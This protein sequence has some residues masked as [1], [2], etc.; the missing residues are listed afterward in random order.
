MSDKLFWT[1]K[2]CTA[3]S[4]HTACTDHPAL[5]AQCSFLQLVLIVLH[6]FLIHTTT[7]T[8]TVETLETE[9][10]VETGLEM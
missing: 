10:T 5:T 3:L 9:E 6:V 7:P 4:A 8:E 2:N 1:A